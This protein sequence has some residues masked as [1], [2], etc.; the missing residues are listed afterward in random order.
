MHRIHME[1]KTATQLMDFNI[2]D[3]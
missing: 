1:I 3:L 2:W